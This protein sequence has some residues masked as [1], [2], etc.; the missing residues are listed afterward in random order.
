MWCNLSSGAVREIWNWSLLGVKGL[1]VKLGRVFAA[2]CFFRVFLLVADQEQ[3][4]HLH[5]QSLSSK[6]SS[7]LIQ[8]SSFRLYSDTW[9]RK[10]LLRA[11]SDLTGHLHSDF[12]SLSV[13]GV[14]V[15][16]TNMQNPMKWKGSNNP[17]IATNYWFSGFLEVGDQGPLICTG[18]IHFKL[19]SDICMRKAPL[20]AFS[21]WTVIFSCIFSTLCDAI[22]LVQLQEKLDD[23]L[24]SKSDQFQI[25]PA[26][27]PE[28]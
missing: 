17:T 26:A 12:S 23:P 1:V 7:S 24:T 11:F 22:F 13:L 27:A 8:I 15:L 9:T 10:A 25:S 20:R 19:Y 18:I 4:S 28:I 3:Q 16:K 21:N 14:P 5:V 6:K 2:K